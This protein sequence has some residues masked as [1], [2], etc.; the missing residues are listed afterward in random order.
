MTKMKAIIWTQYGP[1][2]VLQLQSVDTPQPKDQ[3]I[4]IRVVT[5]NV[6]TGD[7]EMRRFKIHPSMWVPVRLFM[8]LMKPRIKIMGQELSGIVVATGK[9]VTHF[10]TGDAIMACT[11]ARFGSYAEYICL[12]ESYAITLKPENL[13]FEAAATLPVGGLHALHFLRKSKLAKNEKILIFGAGG[14]IGTYAV[15][16]ARNL[17][18]EVTVV[19]SADKLDMLR[20]IGARHVIDYAKEDFSKNGILYDVIFD[21][22]GK[23]PYA[24]SLNSL[25]RTGRYLLANIGLSVMLRGW[26]TSKRT[27]RKV[28]FSAPAMSASNLKHLATLLAEGKLKSVIDKHYR[29]DE[30]VEAH[31]YIDTGKKQGHVV[32]NVGSTGA[33]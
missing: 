6:F 33:E 16:I 27:T 31:K 13:S 14:C 11:G 8:G 20:S 3:E 18:A 15:Q 32:L 25:K 22:A 29:L 1:P 23:S 19:D 17:G 7:C 9:E 21:V 2:E 26:W 4:L 24:R 28:L 30:V 10:N 5:S 12:P